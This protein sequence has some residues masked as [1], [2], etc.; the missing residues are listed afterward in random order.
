[1]ES[2][3][4]QLLLLALDL[5]RLDV[6]VKDPAAKRVATDLLTACPSP[7]A[8]VSVL[9]SNSYGDTP[10]VSLV[11]R[12]LSAS[13]PWIPQD[14]WLVIDLYNTAIQIADNSALL[15]NDV[16]ASLLEFA[17]DLCKF[18]AD[19]SGR[20][21]V[22]PAVVAAV[23][24]A[25]AP[26][27][28]A[29]SAIVDIRKTASSAGG[30][31]EV[32]AVTKLIHA[33]RRVAANRATVAVVQLAPMLRPMSLDDGDEALKINTLSD[34]RDFQHA[35]A[36]LE[37]LARFGQHSQKSIRS[38][39][40]DF[41]HAMALLETL[42][43]FG[44][45]SRRKDATKAPAA[46]V[47]KR[48]RCEEEP[49]RAMFVVNPHEKRSVVVAPAATGLSRRSDG[50][51]VVPPTRTT[52]VVATKVV[53][54]TPSIKSQLQGLYDTPPPSAIPLFRE[55]S[56]SNTANDDEDDDTPPR[57]QPQIS[58]PEGGEASPSRKTTPAPM[59]A[60]NILPPPS[61]NHSLQDA[62][63][64]RLHHGA[65]C[66]DA[67]L[68][69]DNLS[70]V[71]RSEEGANAVSV[72]SSSSILEHSIVVGNEQPNRPHQGRL[73]GG[74]VFAPDVTDSSRDVL[75][76]DLKDSISAVVP[77]SAKVLPIGGSRTYVLV[78]SLQKY[79]PASVVGFFD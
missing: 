12:F 31:F 14:V 49:A 62:A 74:I 65:E 45:H 10:R 52:T 40:R 15:N 53:E 26:L 44:Q 35:M 30:M 32:D 54:R 24:A 77:Q 23:R 5:I 3:A 50:A 59:S 13:M 37:T 46:V 11:S 2:E 60:S 73:P 39:P 42:A 9:G 71:A 75:P 64:R 43:R 7:T 21:A 16:L 18:A 29:V 6:V 61:P 17:S 48:P 28:A 51:V 19:E 1:M 4:F 78:P 38:D 76:K 70:G 25:G 22:A 57:G 20:T 36:L 67:S 41:Q 8:T 79:V 56:L 68:Q 69:L 33:L 55:A 34:P 27:R 58:M 72:A 66:S 63:V 47:S